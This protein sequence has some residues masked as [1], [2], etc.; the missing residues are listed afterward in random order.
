MRKII[1]VFLILTTAGIYGPS[2]QMRTQP[3][4]FTAMPE[5]FGKELF[6]YRIYNFADLSERSKSVA[7]VHISLVNDLL[8]FIKTD[9]DDFRA[10]YTLEAIV[11][12]D[13]HESIA[14]Q[15]LTDT[16]RVPYYSETNDRNKIKRNM[17]LFSLPP[18][19]YDYRIQ[20]F[21]G[22]N[23]VLVQ[24]DAKME[25]A[26]F[27]PEHLQMSDVV[28][29]DQLNCRTQ[30]FTPNLRNNFFDENSE[31]AVFFEIYPPPSNDSL[32][33]DY[34]VTDATGTRLLEERKKKHSL[35]K[36]VFCL[37][38]R[39]HLNQPGEYFFNVA[40]R[41][42]NRVVK[43]QQKFTISWGNLSLKG[44][45]LA[46]AIEQLN[47]IA[48]GDFVRQLRAAE[49]EEQW[50]LYDAFWKERDPTPATD[51]NELKDVFF[52]RIDFAN[53]N[54]TEPRRGREGWRTDR[55]RVFIRNGPPDEIEKM[56]TEPNMPTAEIWYYRKLNRRYIFSDSQGIGEYRLVKVE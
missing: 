4:S 22:E 52:E 37:P 51:K 48:K 39:D 47:L 17:F 44:E 14:Y 23:Q 9:A 3:S 54:F 30:Q 13:N 38:L 10:I 1:L 42:E 53:R 35:S 49:E 45:N 6:V 18:G 34:S 7:Q 41:L 40:V 8:N 31:F 55:G 19:K 21:D 43:S 20:L 24:Q 2:A 27:A 25:L 50:R 28:F 29:A 46:L 26:D 33:I 5:N 36:M 32:F 16:L 15:T 56:P 12:N 11:Y